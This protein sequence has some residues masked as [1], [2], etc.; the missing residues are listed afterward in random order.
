VPGVGIFRAVFAKSR[1][2]AVHFPYINLYTLFYQMYTYI[3]TYIFLNYKHVFV[4][5]VVRVIIFLSPQGLF[6]FPL[7]D[8]SVCFILYKTLFMFTSSVVM[9]ELIIFV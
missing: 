9:I 1:C 2:S 5:S 4:F 7:F 8:F 6:R 3:H